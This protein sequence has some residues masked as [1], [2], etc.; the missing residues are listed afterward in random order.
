MTL[1]E[2]LTETETRLTDFARA[3]GVSVSVAHDWKTKRRFPRGRALAEIERVTEGKVRAADFVP[4][5]AA[6]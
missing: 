2:Y 6:E 5:Q 4:Q 1:S 3:V